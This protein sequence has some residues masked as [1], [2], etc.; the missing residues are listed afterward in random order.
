MTQTNTVTIRQALYI[1]KLLLQKQGTYTDE[2][3]DRVIVALEEGLKMSSVEASKVIDWLVR[4][5]V[6]IHPAPNVTASD[7]AAIIPNVVAGLKE[8]VVSAGILFKAGGETPVATLVK[9]PFAVT[10]E[11]VAAAMAPKPSAVEITEG[12]WISDDGP[13]S[14]NVWKVQPGKIKY[15]GHKPGL[16]AKKLRVWEE[17]GKKKGRFEYV[18]GGIYRLKENSPRPLTIPEAQK[19]GKLFGVCA[20]CGRVL[21]VADSVDRMLGPHCFNILKSHGHVLVA[22][23]HKEVD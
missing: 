21:S 14:I 12:F 1:A 13:D 19:Y 4:R 8:D 2:F 17:G 23:D 10:A 16:Y 6:V 9:V 20:R 5:K 3:R 22:D 18:K 7:I 11:S 15:A